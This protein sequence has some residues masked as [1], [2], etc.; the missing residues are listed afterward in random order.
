[1]VNKLQWEKYNAMPDGDSD[2]ML[3]QTPFGVCKANSANNPLKKYNFWLAN[4]NFAITKKIQSYLN[5]SAGIDALIVIGKYQFIISIAKLFDENIVKKNI[6]KLL[7]INKHIS[8]TSILNKKYKYWIAYKFPNNN[9]IY[10]GHDDI[11]EMERI[12]KVYQNI[13]DI[14]R[15]KIT[16]SK[17]FQRKNNGN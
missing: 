13:K 11:A 10:S 15:G 4:T 3:V 14:S 17:T 2:D 6:E 16:L 7:N 1:M 9:L 8:L 5:Q 12:A